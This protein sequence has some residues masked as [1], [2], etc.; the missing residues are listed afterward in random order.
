MLF[1]G[2]RP[3][4]QTPDR[5][6]PDRKRAE[7]IDVYAGFTVAGDPGVFL[8][9]NKLRFFL[10]GDQAWR[11]SNEIADALETAEQMLTVTHTTTTGD[12]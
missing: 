9:G 3:F 6:A 4:V 5:V 7:S 10:P 12:Q 8:S 2:T 1:D 11:I